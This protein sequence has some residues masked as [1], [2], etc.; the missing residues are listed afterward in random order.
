MI[1]IPILYIVLGVLVK[2]GKMYFLIAGY[3]TMT[4]DQRAKYDISGIAGLLCNTMFGMALVLVLGHLAA[5]WLK[6][7]EIEP[8][9]FYGAHLI[10]LPYL[11][12]RA[13]SKKYRKLQ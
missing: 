13:N 8:I 12:I 1:A 6:L 11:L 9:S 4:K 10:G 5:P 2:Y 7:P 3:N